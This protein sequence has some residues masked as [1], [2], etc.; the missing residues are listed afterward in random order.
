MTFHSFLL[1]VSPEHFATMWDLRIKPTPGKQEYRMGGRSWLEGH[2][3]KPWIKPSLKPIRFL[4]LGH[5]VTPAK[6]IPI[7][8]SQLELGFCHPW[9]ELEHPNCHTEERKIVQDGGLVLA[10]EVT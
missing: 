10:Y 7:Y 6:K 9:Q 5:S 2:S 4:L 1:S 3:G 8:V